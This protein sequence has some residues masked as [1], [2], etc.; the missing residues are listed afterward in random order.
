MKSTFKYA[1]MVIDILQVIYNNPGISISELRK[2][3]NL[4]SSTMSI[5][6]KELKDS[7]IVFTL[8]DKKKIIVN[9]RN[10]DS[11]ERVVKIKKVFPLGVS[12]N[13]FGT[14]IIPHIVNSNSNSGSYN[15]GLKVFSCPFVKECPYVNQKTLIPGYC[16]LYDHLS[17]EEKKAIISI[18]DKINSL[19]ELAKYS[20]SQKN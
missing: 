7:G 10:G 11:Y 1:K 18:M 3:F 4:P 15:I 5:I 9:R 8:E 17:D 12:C 19:I 2:I 6:I 13:S 14:V 20:T 16:K